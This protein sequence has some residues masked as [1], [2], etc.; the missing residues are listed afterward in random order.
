MAKDGWQVSGSVDI[1]RWESF[2]LAD[3]RVLTSI[4]VRVRTK[5]YFQNN[6]SSLPRSLLTV[7]SNNAKGFSILKFP[8]GTLHSSFLH[9]RTVLQLGKPVCLLLSRSLLISVRRPVDFC[10]KWVCPIYQWHGAEMNLLHWTTL[11]PALPD[12]RYVPPCTL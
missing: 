3:A 1:S 12:S 7:R 2:D 9:F 4:R 10:A 6:A 5:V 11:I 8:F